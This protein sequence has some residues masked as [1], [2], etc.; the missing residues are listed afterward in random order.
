M[1]TRV[2]Q[3]IMELRRQGIT[4]TR[5]LAAIERVPRERFVADQ[6]LKHA[7]DN[8]ALPITQGQT[9]SQPFVVAYMTEALRLGDRMK[10]LEIGTGSGYQSMVLAKLCRRVYTIERYRS[11]LQTAQRRFADLGVNNITAKLGDG[12]KGWVEQAPF[13]RILV[14]AAADRRPETLLEQLSPDGGIMVAPV[15]VSAIEQDVI[16][17]TRTGDDIQEE[18]LL[19]VRFVPLLPGIA[20]E[21]AG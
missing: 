15:A 20:R 9:I 12:N 5:V 17:Y 7:Y 13:D 18:R 11:L 14:T 16:R 1:E 10:V 3:L 19:P 21:A 4:D 8:I 6:F 2:I